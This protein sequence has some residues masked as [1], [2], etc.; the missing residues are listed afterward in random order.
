MKYVVE[1]GSDIIMHIPS[2]ILIGSGIQKR[3]GSRYADTQT[4]RWS[5]VTKQNSVASVREQTTQT[6]RP[7]LVDEVSSN[8]CG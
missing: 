4:A 3:V 8:F 1:M 7:P 6:K 2:F 5:N